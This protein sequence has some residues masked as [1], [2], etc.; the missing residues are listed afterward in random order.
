MWAFRRAIW[1]AKVEPIHLLHEAIVIKGGN[2]GNRN[3]HQQDMISSLTNASGGDVDDEYET[4]RSS[5]SFR[6]KPSGASNR[7]STNSLEV[8]SE[9]AE[10][11]KENLENDGD[12]KIESGEKRFSNHSNSAAI[13]MDGSIVSS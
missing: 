11:G 13:F 1:G 10:L 5:L 2:K 6:W 7:R 8:I 9:T 4:D 3:V 12:Q